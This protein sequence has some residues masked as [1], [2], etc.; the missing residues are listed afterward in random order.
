MCVDQL[1]SISRKRDYRG[2][3]PRPPLREMVRTTHAGACRR[4]LLLVI[5]SAA[6][7]PASFTP[8][9]A[10][11][12]AVFYALRLR[13]VRLPH[14][15]WKALPE[16]ILRARRCSARR[17]CSSSRLSG[18]FAWVLTI[19]SV[20]QTLAAAIVAME[21]SP[22]VFLIAV[23][24]LLLLFGIFMEPLPGVMVLVPILA[25]IA[26]TLGI[27]PIHFASS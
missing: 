24:V 4:L 22:I 1:A 21:L 13:Q 10:S 17:C 9:E 15:E 25:P 23:N 11:V 27:D 18:A 5:I 7:A 3:E 12:V 2:D 16:I 14:A 8:T 20:P 19:E 6:S 26:T